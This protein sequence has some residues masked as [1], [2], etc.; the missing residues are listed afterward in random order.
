LVEVLRGEQA[1]DE[2]WDPVTAGQK[3]TGNFKKSKKA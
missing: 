1:P 2:I 3:V